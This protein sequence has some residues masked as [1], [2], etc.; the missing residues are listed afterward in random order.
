M[1]REKEG[2]SVHAEGVASGGFGV[3]A[4]LYNIGSMEG[5]EL[6][7]YKSVSTG[8]ERTQTHF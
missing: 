2:R 7:V 6:G 3:K 5:S 4:T 1:K 8:E